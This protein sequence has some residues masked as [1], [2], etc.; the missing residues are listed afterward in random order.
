MWIANKIFHRVHVF[1]PVRDA[2]FS[3]NI[4]TSCA[5]LSIHL[6]LSNS[7]AMLKTNTHIPKQVL[8]FANVFLLIFFLTV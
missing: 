2:K 3:V 1:S 7:A 8:Y 6:P 5:A 4:T